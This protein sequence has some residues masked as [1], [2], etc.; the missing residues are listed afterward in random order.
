[1]YSQALPSENG[2]GCS[3]FSKKY[4]SPFLKFFN[5]IRLT[6]RNVGP[7][8]DLGTCRS[9]APPTD[10]STSSK[11]SQMLYRRLTCWND[12]LFNTLQFRSPIIVILL[13]VYISENPSSFSLFPSYRILRNHYMEGDR[14]LGHVGDLLT[15][16][17][18]VYLD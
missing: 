17:L 15:L 1:M 18:S 12:K 4:R 2:Y 14:G 10:R 7:T 3:L 6:Q 16:N 5:C 9:S 13:L 11:D 8:R